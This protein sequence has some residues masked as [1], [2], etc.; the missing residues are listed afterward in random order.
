MNAKW[1]K[2]TNKHSDHVTNNSF[3]QGAP[4]ENGSKAGM[5]VG[6]GREEGPHLVSNENE[7]GHTCVQCGKVFQWKSNLTKHMRTHTGEKPYNCELCTYKTSYSE[8]LK[9]H[10]RI[11]T[12]EKPYKCELCD[13]RS[14]DYGSLKQHLKKHSDVP[15]WVGSKGQEGDNLFKGHYCNRLNH[16]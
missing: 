6:R 2:P 14:R 3:L 9:R 15:K 12:G 10:M 7:A 1:D 5:S 11:H 13:Y 8:A 4:Q 16:F